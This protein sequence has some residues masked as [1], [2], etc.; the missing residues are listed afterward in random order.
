MSLLDAAR[1]LSCRTSPAAPSRRM[2]WHRRPTGAGIS[3]SRCASPM[4]SL[5]SA[6]WTRHLPG[7]RPAPTLCRLSRRPCSKVRTLRNWCRRC[8]R[9][10]MT[11]ARFSTR[12]VVCIWRA[13]RSNGARSMCSESG[14]RCVFR[15]RGS[16]ARPVGLRRRRKIGA[17][18]AV[19]SPDTRCSACA[20]A[21]RLP[22][23][24][25]SR[26]D[27][28]AHRAVHRRP[29]RGWPR[30]HAGDRLHRDGS[31]C[32]PARCRQ[33]SCL[34]QPRDCRAAS[35]GRRREPLRANGGSHVRREGRELRDRLERRDRQWRRVDAP[36]ARRDRDRRGG[37][38]GANSAPRTAPD[39]ANARAALRCA[40]C[41]RPRIR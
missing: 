6:P 25:S 33:L 3:W 41:A 37:T 4:A 15:P 14:D 34:E 28:R 13:R 31:G 24:C 10:A 38:R 29:H 23:S 30:D 21:R 19:S 17:L 16:S 39:T 7:G 1:S 35:V 2:T 26:N 32:W 5:P 8:A 12:S 40:W 27:R 11:G 20:F 22:M 36:R 18:C 9:A